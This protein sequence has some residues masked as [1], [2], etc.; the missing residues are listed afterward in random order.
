M[1]V[2]FQSLPEW[3]GS[4]RGLLPVESTIMVAIPELDG[5]TGPMRLRR[6]RRRRRAAP[7][8]AAR[9]PAT[10]RPADTQDMHTC[11]ERTAMLAARVARLVA[12][13]RSAARRAPRGDGAVQLPAQRRQ[14]RH[15]G[16]PVGVRER[17]S[18]TLKAPEA[19]RATPSTLPASVDA[20]RDAVLQGNAERS[21]RRRCQRAGP[22]PGR[23]PRAARALAQGDRGRLGPGAGQAAQRRRSIFVLGAQFGNVFVGVQPGM[24]YEGD[25]M[26]LLFERGF[27]PTHAFS[28]FYRW[29]RED[30][31]AH[32]VLHFGTH[33]ALEFM[34]GKQTGLSG[35]AG[36]TG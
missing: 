34:P 21:A 9:R 19:P 30:F 29:L 17:C 8:R 2:E 18:N 25:P 20:L 27:A 31:K 10:S 15:R 33:G 24:G 12:L 4:E 26:R 22:H 35:A 5:A 3:G 28:A 13:R 32:A 11:S 23:R 14:H 36:P 1:P 6:P 16:L 7:A